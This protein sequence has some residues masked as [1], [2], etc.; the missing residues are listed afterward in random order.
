MAGFVF[1]PDKA[2]TTF[3]EEMKREQDQLRRR[4]VHHTRPKGPLSLE[5]AIALSKRMEGSADAVHE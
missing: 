2:H 4:F 3:A 1:E 5:E